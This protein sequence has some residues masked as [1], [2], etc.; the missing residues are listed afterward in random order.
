MAKKSAAKKVEE[1]SYDEV[2]YESFAYPQT[3]PNNVS[4]IATLFGLKAPNFK[5]A[6]VLE[7]GCASGG[8]IAPMAY[9][10]PDAKF[11]GIDI[12]GEQIKQ[13]N[14]RKK[15]LDL[16]NVEFLQQDIL[17]LKA[18]SKKD[19]YDYII[20]HGVFSWV[21]EKVREGILKSC[22]KLLSPNGIAVVSYNALP[23]WNAVR[24]VREMMLY[25]TNRFE[26]P[27]DKV[28]QA[29]LLLD[30][31]AENVPAGQVGYK[32]VIESEKEMLQKTH[33]MYM[34]HDHLEAEN[35]Q[36][37]LNDFVG[38]ARENGLE[39]VG[40]AAL[41][42]MY[43]GN[44]SANVMDKLQALNDIVAQEQYM[45]FV[46]NRRFRTSILCKQDRKINRNLNKEQIMDYYLTF[47]PN[48]QVEGTDPTKDILFK[49]GGGDFTTHDP[50]AGNLFLELATSG[51][52]PVSANDLIKRVQEKTGEKSDEKIKA[53]LMANGLQLVLKGY[54]NLHSY[55]IDFVSKVSKKPK[56]SPVAR[57]EA[58][59]PQTLA[60]TNLLNFA[61]P[62]D[63]I[64]KIIVANLDGTNTKEDIV[65]ILMQA[66]E[67]GDININRDDA[68]LKDKAEIKKHVKEV[69]S[70]VLGKLA[71]N[72][73]L[74]E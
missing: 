2:P 22:N 7:I 6:R 47:N 70:V 33:S 44:M 31:L 58:G 19:Q 27:N 69:V 39:Y 30:F 54:I 35:A 50:L 20:C 62:T 67:N 63:M 68:P 25:H 3:H 74:I 43:V 26:N 59:L 42:S 65:D 55:T 16:K 64:A 66:I 40:D 24:S 1:K 11:V 10:Y 18:G 57:Y 48:I 73:L 56:V 12:S 49:I 71:Q 13:A 36:F 52:V 37:Y 17:D 28:N 32:A 34:Y 72:A 4:T 21:P 8:N 51:S 15:A 29:R 61:I 38:M 60:L 45:D 14:E 5:K 46:T 23:G 53:I 41:A 9:A